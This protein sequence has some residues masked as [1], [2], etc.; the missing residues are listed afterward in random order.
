MTVYTTYDQVGIEEDVSNVITTIDPTDT[1]MFTMMKAE[2]V[3]NRVFHWQEDTLASAADN[4]QIEG[5]NASYATLT[6]TTMR[7]NSTQILTKAFQVSETSDAVSTYGRAKETAYQL[8]KKLAEIKLD[9]ERAFIGVDN[10]KVTGTTSAAREMASVSQMISTTV[11]A[12]TNATDA[13]TETKLLELGQTCYQNGSK[14]HVLMIKPADSIIVSGFVSANTGRNRDISQER[15][16]VNVIDLYVSPYGEYKVIMNRHQLTTHAFLIDPAM[17]KTCVLRPFTRTLLAK[18][19]DAD[20]HFIRGEYS[21]M[22]KSFADS[23]MI[24]GLS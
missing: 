3:R 9:L 13:L 16:L 20:N 18:T 11:D 12:G 10:A 6:P 1:P 23:G 24:T 2:K 22:H 19:G 17:F 8:A 4:A 15:R 14:P 5:A 21:V 7:E